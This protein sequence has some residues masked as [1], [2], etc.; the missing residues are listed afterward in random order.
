MERKW[1][2]DTVIHIY[3]QTGSGIDFVDVLDYDN[4]SGRGESTSFFSADP[5]TY[6]FAFLGYDDS[7]QGLCQI[8]INSTAPGTDADPG[9]GLWGSGYHHYPALLRPI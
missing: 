7:Q 4:K 5:G 1:G 8:E 9:R 3:K 6:Y 2:I